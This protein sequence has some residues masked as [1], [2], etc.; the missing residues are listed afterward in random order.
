MGQDS[1]V[2]DSRLI[3]K[4][5]SGLHLSAD[6]I[7]KEDEEYKMYRNVKIELRY[8]RSLFKRLDG[9]MRECET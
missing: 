7:E 2:G 3:C 6:S 8:P 4:V 1:M 9:G 5:Y